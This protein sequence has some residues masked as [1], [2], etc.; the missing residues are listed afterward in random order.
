RSKRQRRI[1]LA[2]IARETRHLQ[3]RA[4]HRPAQQRQPHQQIVGTRLLKL[5]EI[6]IPRREFLLH[7]FPQ[8]SGNVAW[9]VLVNGPER[10]PASRPEGTIILLYAYTAERVMVCGLASVGALSTTQR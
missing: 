8:S 4:K 7:D 9:L 2:H 5:Y 10:T 1:G 6:K 3:C